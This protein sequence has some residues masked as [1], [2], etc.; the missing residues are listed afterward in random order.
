MQCLKKIR[1]KVLSLLAEITINKFKEG[2]GRN[3]SSQ[4]KNINTQW[5]VTQHPIVQQ[6]Y[7]LNI[8]KKRRKIKKTQCLRIFQNERNISI[9][10]KEV[11]WWTAK[12]IIEKILYSDT[13]W[14]NC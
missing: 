7:N 13:P 10:W 14:T 3:M 4:L 8:R 11:T 2:T 12:K 1:G 5:S 6:V 9:V